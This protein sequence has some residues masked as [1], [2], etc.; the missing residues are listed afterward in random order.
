MAFEYGKFLNER[1]NNAK[2]AIEWFSNGIRVYPR[3]EDLI[4]QYASLQMKEGN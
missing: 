3:N 4:I 2:D 1:M